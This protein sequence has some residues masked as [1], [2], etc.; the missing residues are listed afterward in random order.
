MRFLL[1]NKIKALFLLLLFGLSSN[2]FGQF[3]EKPEPASP[4]NDFANILTSE[5]RTHFIKQLSEFT[6]QTSTQIVL[7]TVSDLMGYD[8]AQYSVEL[9]HKWGIGQKDTDNG[10]LILIK[11]KTVQSR[12]EAYIAV[13]YG[14]EAVVPDAVAKQIVEYEMIPEF[15]AGDYFAGLA[16]TI[17]VLIGLT[18]NEYTA[19]QYTESKNDGLAGLIPLLIFIVIFIIFTSK[20]KNRASGVGTRSAI[21]WWTLMLLGSTMGG[22]RRNSGWSDFNSGG[23]SFGGGGGFGGFGGGGFGGGG[24]G[25]SW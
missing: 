12:G 18:K 24:A 25:G 23:G 10:I 14:L 7:V 22:G 1:V 11:P 13:G 3:P 21:P 5:Q 8:K 19:K 20:G 9:A 4:V 17:D 15:K 2:L 16:K 6:Q